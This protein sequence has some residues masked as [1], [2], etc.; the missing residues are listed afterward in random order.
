MN[1]TANS[2]V[3]NMFVLSL[4]LPLIFWFSGVGSDGYVPSDVTIIVTNINIKIE[5]TMTV[6]G[7][8]IVRL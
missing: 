8:C 6:I 1:P 4:L 5:Q 7:T 3:E 2:N